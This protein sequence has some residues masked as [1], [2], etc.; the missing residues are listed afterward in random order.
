[1][2]AASYIVLWVLTVVLMVTVV[3]LSRQ[4]AELERTRS[5][6]AGRDGPRVG[7]RVSPFEA[8]DTGGR[9]ITIG[10]TDARAQLLV[11]TSPSCAACE[12]VL[13]GIDTLTDGGGLEAVIVTDV[14]AEESRL[15]YGGRNLA[16]PVVAGAELFHAL[17][18]PGTPYLV[19]LG[20]G[21]TVRG[22]G[23]ATTFER[24]QDLV[25]AARSSR[26]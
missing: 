24:A 3:S 2:W 12:V 10:G 23:P 20:S 17:A 14:D 11:F 26:G 4:V 22:K 6:S 9:E 15:V 1:L 25:A 5:G 16:A 8:S 19:V 18:I 13:A 21:G 7:D